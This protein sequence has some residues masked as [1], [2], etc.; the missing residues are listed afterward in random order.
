MRR[1]IL[2]VTSL[3][4]ASSALAQV[5]AAA[6]SGI[7]GASQ[8]ITS[9]GAYLLHSVQRKTPNVLRMHHG[10]DD[11][12]KVQKRTPINPQAIET[13]LSIALA[14]AWK[15][16]FIEVGVEETR[17][18]LLECQQETSVVLTMPFMRSDA[19]QAHCYRF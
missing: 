3:L 13:T 1:A 12:S 8:F 6:N 19:Q 4:V 17:R 9:D 15:R 14:Q 7:E 2:L 5:S 11:V 18:V 10:D 16:G